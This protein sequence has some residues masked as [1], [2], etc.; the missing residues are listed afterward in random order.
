M[1]PAAGPLVAVDPPSGQ[2]T[3][4][5]NSVAADT[6]PEVSPDAKK[7]AYVNTGNIFIADWP[8]GNNRQQITVTGGFSSPAWN[9]TSTGLVFDGA[10]GL[11]TSPITAPTPTQVVGSVAGDDTPDYNPA[12]NLI[13]FTTPGPDIGRL[14]ADNTGARSILQGT[15]GGDN[16]PRVSPA[17][18][19]VVFECATG[20]CT[21]PFPNGGARTQLLGTLAGDDDPTY[22]PDG[23]DVIFGRPGVGIRFVNANGTG[24]ETVLGGSLPGDTD[25]SWGGA[26]GLV[27]PPGFNR[28]PTFS[29]ASNCGGVSLL[30][31]LPLLGPVSTRL[32]ATDPDTGQTLVVGTAVPA[33]G[34]SFLSVDARAGN[35]ASV[36]FGLSLGRPQAVMDFVVAAFFMTS[37]EVSVGVSDNGDP[38]L[39]AECNKTIRVAVL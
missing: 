21:M 7:V 26:D 24:A 30:R 1:D 5:Q 27:A 6:E 36:T 22:S 19:T 11:F 35:P 17:G 20:G 16:H 18:N 31:L 25:P 38:P 28:P 9:P 10:A 13:V 3:S 2:R 15:L 12:G 14:N 8:S 23:A 34:W 39:S 33:A 4:L 37:A 29:E 32:E